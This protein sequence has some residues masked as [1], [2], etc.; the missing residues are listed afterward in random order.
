MRKWRNHETRRTTRNR[1]GKTKGMKSNN[2]TTHERKEGRK[3]ERNTTHCK[4]KKKHIVKK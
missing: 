2:D 1:A 3:E 4:S